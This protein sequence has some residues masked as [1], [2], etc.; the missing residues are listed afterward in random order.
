MATT[1]GTGT[2]NTSTGVLAI[3]QLGSYNGQSWLGSIDDVRIYNRALAPNEVSQLYNWAP[4]PVARYSFD[5]GSGSTV[6][7]ISGNGNNGTWGGSGKTHW[8]HGKYGWAGNFNGSSDY[9]TVPDSSSLDITGGITIEAWAK[10]NAIQ[11]SRWPGM[12]VKTTDT[13]SLTNGYGIRQQSNTAILQPWIGNGTT[14][15]GNGSMSLPVGQWHY[16]TMTYT[17]GSGGTVY[18]DGVAVGSISNGGNISPTSAALHIGWDGSGSYFNGAIDDVQIYNYARNQK[19]ITSDMNGG[20]PAGGSP[21][22]SQVGYWKFDEGY[23]TVAHNS[24][25]QGS[26]LN[27]SISSAT[28]TNAG[29]FCKALSFN[30]SSSLVTVT[31]TNTLSGSYTV[32]AWVNPGTTSGVIGI[33]GSR[34]SG[35]DNSFDLKFQ[36]DNLIHADI[37]NG[38]SWLVTNADYPYVYSS[39]VWY[40]VA[41][42]VSP[43]GYTIYLNGNQVASGTFSGTPLLY[44]TT[45]IFHIGEGYY[46]GENWNGTIDEVKVYPSALTTAEIAIDYNH[47]SAVAEGVLGTT[48]TGAADNS[49]DRAY[50]PPGDTTGTCGPIGDWEFEEG[51]GTTVNDSSGGGDTGTWN[52]SGKQHWVQGHTGWGGNFNGTND[53]VALNNVALQNLSSGTVTFWVKPQ[54]WGGTVIYEDGGG[55]NNFAANLPAN[56]GSPFTFNLDNNT[57]RNTN[58]SNWSLNQWYYITVTWTSSTIT[59]YVNGALD[60]TISASGSTGSGGNATQ[61]GRYCYGSYCGTSGGYMGGQLDQI[62]FYNYA[63]SAAQVAWDYNRGAPLGYWKFDECQG[64]TAHDSSGNGNN[65]TITIGGSGTQTGLGTCTSQ[66]DGTGKDAWYNGAIGKYNS[67]LNFD[68]TDDYIN[69]G[70]TSLPTGNPAYSISVWFK[71]PSIPTT[72]LGA[73]LLAWGTSGTTNEIN[74]FR[75]AD[76]SECANGGLINYWWAND[77]TA[78][79]SSPLTTNTW[80]LATAT[81]NGTTRSIY[82]DDVLLKNDTPTGHNITGTQGYIGLTCPSGGCTD[83]FNG[84][85]DDVRIYNYA[86]TSQQVQLLYNQGGAI[87]YGP[88]SGTP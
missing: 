87:R 34:N 52:G 69:L 54:V 76:T 25:N 70:T 10:T 28:W 72:Y 11:V 65:G 4:G 23:G 37:G 18:E 74:A 61:I 71:I 49:A 44:D 9:V 88:S 86:L 6:N 45:H 57:T 40:Y 41:Y 75:L 47:G 43:T 13:S 67:S 55:H 21:I 26:A 77:M 64:T 58:K 51:S 82:L 8:V 62:R 81:F 24:G 84:Q 31:P 7:D 35:A 14:A 46:T 22:G 20:H 3:G 27:G 60:N 19:Q 16:F 48:S 79:L 39:G 78:C 56:A 17:S 50:C 68:G 73:G 1:T 80:H 33:M 59:T 42:V 32:S 12:V 38:S 53:Y 66:P 15:Y 29:K 63:R 36:N 83:Y 5:E 2:M 30:G 85:I